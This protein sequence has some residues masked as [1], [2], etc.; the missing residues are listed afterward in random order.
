MYKFQAQYVYEK[1]HSVM[2]AV[3]DYGMDD[4]G[5]ALCWPIRA[6]GNLCPE[7]RPGVSRHRICV[8]EKGMGLKGGREVWGRGAL[9]SCRL[10]RLERKQTRRS[11][12]GEQ[13]PGSE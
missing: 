1:R 6:H 12:F 8:W 9:T 3:I 2:P 13:R 4:D 10:L 11:S 7:A 5:W